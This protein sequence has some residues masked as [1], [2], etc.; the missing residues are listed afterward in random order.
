M[1]HLRPAIVLLLLFTVLTGIA[2]PLAL[3]G[4]ASALFP[5]QAQGEQV[6]RDGK[7]VGS[8][9]IGQN[10]VSARYFQ[11]R[12]SAT[13]APDPKDPSKT[14]DAPYNASNSGGSNLGPTSKALSDRV[15]AAVEEKRQAGWTAPLPADALTTSASGLD[16]DISPE[17][18]LAQA[19]AVARERGIDGEKLRHLVQAHIEK[20]LFGVIGERHVNVLLLNLALDD[21][22]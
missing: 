11:P 19:P 1:N 22:R 6:L 17:N 5:W 8:A 10:F 4:V 20:P 12:P 21:L 9:L 16:P 2:Y 18:A 13:T 14:V 15:K 3:T 7:L